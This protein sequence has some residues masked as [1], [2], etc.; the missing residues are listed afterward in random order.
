MATT[1]T[2][3]INGLVDTSKN[4][5]DNIN[6]MANQSGAFIS[7]DPNTGKWI[8]ILK[9]EQS[10][11]ISLE[12]STKAGWYSTRLGKSDFVSQL[13]RYRHGP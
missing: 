10:K 8:A 1:T 12:K 2:F 13:H 7:W 3:R 6:T 9:L 11:R 5:L 4:V